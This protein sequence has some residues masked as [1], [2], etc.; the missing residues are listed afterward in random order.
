[1]LFKKALLYN[2]KSLGVGKKSYLNLWENHQCEMLY[3]GGYSE[4]MTST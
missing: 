4:F 1:M 2:S 3:P